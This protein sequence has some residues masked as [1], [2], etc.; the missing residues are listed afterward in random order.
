M[1]KTTENW[2]EIVAKQ[3]NHIAQLERKL[4]ELEALVKFYEEQFRLAKHRQFGASSE[5]NKYDHLQLSIF[6]EAEATSDLTLAEPEL[7]AA[8]FFQRI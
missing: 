3:E 2:P 6:N 5:K 7:V 8:L 4:N 1:M